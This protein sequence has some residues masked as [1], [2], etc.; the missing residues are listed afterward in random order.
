MSE[1]LL[2]ENPFKDI[3]LSRITDFSKMWKGC[4]SLTSFPDVSDLASNLTPEQMAEIRNR[5]EG[6]IYPP[7][8]EL[9][10]LLKDK[11]S[12]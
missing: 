5:G 12:E 6:H 1:G 4:T 11:A 7:V 8:H 3:D 10:E 2:E 9:I